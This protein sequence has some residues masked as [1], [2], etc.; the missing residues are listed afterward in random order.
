[1]NQNI[2][3]FIAI[4]HDI[5]KLE[6]YKKLLKNKL[7]K[8]SGIVN[9]YVIIS[10]TDLKGYIT[11]VSEA[12]CKVSGYT[13][14]ELVGSNHNI[15]RHPDVD[16]KV[17]KDLWNTVKKGNVWKGEVKN[18]KKDG[19]YYWVYAIISPIF[20]ENNKITGYTAVR[21]DI[22]DKKIIEEISQKDKLTQIYNRVKLD[23]VLSAEI[24]RNRR[25]Q[26]DFSVIL[27]DI[28]KFKSVNDNYGHN[29]GD[30][31]LKQTANLLNNSLRK[32]DTLGRWGGEEFLIICTNTKLEGAFNLAEH[33]RKKMEQFKFDHIGRVT[34]SFGVSI[35]NKGETEEILLKKCDDA[36][37]Q[38]KKNG[39][40]R[41]EKK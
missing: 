19:G 39:R 8:Y 18:R 34:A 26:V 12:F 2:K 11:F 5:T 33:L 32:T 38:A 37:Y 16:K 29:V 9:E 30:I 21:Q 23:E 22:T 25:Y 1:N 24:E 6:N 15:V 7:D 3:E 17:Y 10:N 35:Y 14:D 27:L 13:K 31:I 41:V 40:N 4:R 20:D 28:D 36:L